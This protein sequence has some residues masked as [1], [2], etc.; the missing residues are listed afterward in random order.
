MMLNLIILLAIIVAIFVGISIGASSVPP[1]FGPVR[2][3]G[4][5]GILQSALLAGL[6]AAAGAFFQGGR[7]TNTIGSNIILGEMIGLQALTILLV[8]S[9]LVII[10]VTFKYPMPTAFTVVGAVIGSALSFGNQISSPVLSSIFIFWLAIPFFALAMGYISSKYLRK[11][12][13]KRKSKKMLKYFTLLMGLFLAYTAGAN[14]VGLAVGPLQSFDFSMSFLLVLGGISIL[15]GALILSPKIIDA[16]S[17]EYAGIGA[18]RSSAS[19]GSAAI[20]A[21]IGVFLGVPVSFNQAIIA[22]TIGS[23]LVT[24]KSTIGKKKLL[25]TVGAWFLA[26]LIS[27]VATFALSEALKYFIVI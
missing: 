8:A 19:L 14:S 17:F 22:S 18:R 23:G 10:S 13:D 21:Q 11:F 6:A 12:V 26:F 24:G 20:L 7:V 15:M 1:S 9:I 25:F 27:I 5:L 4:S 16:V 2:S 3:S